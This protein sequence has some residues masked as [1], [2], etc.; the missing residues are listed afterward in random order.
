MAVGLPVITTADGGV[1]DY[2]IDGKNGFLV[3]PADSED[4]Y[5]AMKKI[6]LHQEMIEPM[7]KYNRDFVSQNFTWDNLAGMV[8]KAFENFR[9]K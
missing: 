3:K 2:F 5:Q 9:Q 8:V 6:Y 1:M 7:G 4:L